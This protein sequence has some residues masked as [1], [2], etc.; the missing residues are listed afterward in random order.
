L[1]ALSRDSPS[2]TTTKATR[3]HLLRYGQ[4][5]YSRM[6]VQSQAEELPLNW[7][8]PPEAGFPAS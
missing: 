3:F 1:S 5:I 7:V 4:K 8:P 6:G 2:S